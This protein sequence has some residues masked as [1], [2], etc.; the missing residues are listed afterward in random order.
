MIKRRL[1]FRAQIAR[2]RVHADQEDEEEMKNVA[3]EHRVLRIFINNCLSSFWIK[4]LR[5]CVP[6]VASKHGEEDEDV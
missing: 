5:G 3:A 1:R 4:F 2:N 6:F